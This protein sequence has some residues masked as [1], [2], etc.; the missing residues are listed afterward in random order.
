MSSKEPI[1]R[2]GKQALY[3]F[4]PFKLIKSEKSQEYSLILSTVYGMRV[5]PNIVFYKGIEDKF[6]VKIPDGPEVSVIHPSILLYRTIKKN[7]KKDYIYDTSN[8]IYKFYPLYM[9]FNFNS[10]TKGYY[11]L[12]GLVLLSPDENKCPLQDECNFNPDKS[13][14]V[15]MYYYGPTSYTRLYTVYPQIIEIFDEYGENNAQSILSSQ[16][17][18]ISFLPHGEYKVFINGI[19]FYPKNS[20][21]DYPPMVYLNV[22]LSNK[23]KNDNKLIK[24]GFRIRNSAAIKLEF[25]LKELNTHI[26]EILEKD[27]NTARWIKLKYYLYLAHLKHKTKNK[28]ILRDKGFDA[29]DKMLELLSNENEKDK[30]DE[31]NV[32]NQEDELVNIINFASFLFVHSLA[33]LLLSWISLEYGNTRENFGYYIEHPLLGNM[34]DPDKVRLYI[35]E[36]AIGGLGYLNT[37]ADETTRNKVK[38]LEFINYA[39]NVLSNCRDKVDREIPEFLNILSNTD[40]N[41]KKI[42]KDIELAYKSFDTNLKIFPHVIAIRKYITKNHPEVQGDKDLRIIFTDVLGYA[43]HCWDGCPLCVMY[44]RGCHFS[45]Y[46]QPF[47]VS[48]ELTRVMLEKIEQI[49]KSTIIEEIK[50]DIENLPEDRSIPLNLKKGLAYYYFKASIDLAKESIDIVSPYISPEII[51]ALYDILRQRNIRVR[52]LTTIN[53][54]NKKGLEM[55][56]KLKE[57]KTKIFQA[58]PNTDLHSKNLVIDGRILIFGSF[59][60]TSKGLKGNYENIDVRKDRE[61][62]EDFKKEFEKLWRESEPLK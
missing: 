16:L 14:P 30:V 45:V 60:M 61:A 19:Y 58:D 6:K 21:I 34:K 48:R 11:C 59:N 7:G 32:N 28:S 44:E 23:N 22:K 18:N 4:T 40:S 50:K 42:A 52:L 31:I 57:I 27:K 41:F 37:F 9:R 55:L 46:D 25:N 13:R 24:I 12:L 33:H 15:C 38:L 8:R 35:I 3:S 2:S 10:L 51:E 1:T 17:I 56:K 49:M 47:L 26:R 62:L 29:F 53:E 54:T 39:L 20:Q 36:E 5:K 43:P